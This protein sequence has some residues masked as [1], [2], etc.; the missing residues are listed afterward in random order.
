MTDTAENYDLVLERII[1]APA[2]K[3]FRAWTE[4]ALLKQWFAPRPFTTPIVETDVRPGGKNYFVMQDE[5]GTQYPN[6]G[7][8]LEV[9]PDRKLVFTDAF[10]S[11]WKPS[12]KPFFVGEI[13]LEEVDGK[14]KYTATARHWT[15]EDMETHKQMGFHEGW[16]QCADQLAELVKT[17]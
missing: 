13:L 14:T 12:A 11:A 15:K 10:T 9:V 8:Y 6:H 1:D 2:A 16:G 5:A 17:I 7:V 4:P 3:I